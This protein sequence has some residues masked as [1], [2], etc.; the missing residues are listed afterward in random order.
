MLSRPRNFLEGNEIVPLYSG[1]RKYTLLSS[2]TGPPTKVERIKKE[3]WKHFTRNAEN[4][5]KLL[6]TLA[7]SNACHSQQFCSVHAHQC[8]PVSRGG[9][10]CVS[11]VL[12]PKKHPHER[13]AIWPHRS[14]SGPPSLLGLHLL[15]QLPASLC[16]ADWSVLIVEKKKINLA[17]THGKLAS[18]PRPT[19]GW[20]VCDSGD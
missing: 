11:F 1:T 6:S 18:R 5:Q 12:A 13:S 16:H 2:G 4:T 17:V 20:G 3:R 19:S 9:K 15:G 7:R 10:H 8:V 14:T